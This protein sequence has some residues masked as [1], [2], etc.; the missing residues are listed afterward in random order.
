V[1]LFANDTPWLLVA[2]LVSVAERAAVSYRIRADR[3][4]PDTRPVAVRAP[5][6]QPGGFPP[7]PFAGP[8]RPTSAPMIDPSSPA[9]EAPGVTPSSAPST[10]APAY[11]PGRA[12]VR[13]RMIDGRS[14]QPIAGGMVILGQPGMDLG[15]LIQLYLERRLTDEQFFQGLVGFARTGP[16]GAYELDGIPS[17]QV[18][19]AAGIAQGYR[20]QMLR[21]GIG[22]ESPVLEQNA[23]P[24]LR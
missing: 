13:G 24:M 14:G 22:T 10:Q 23:I 16:D 17:N 8:P 7:N 15:R 20:S 21:I 6:E 1:V 12:T 5:A 2:V 11:G 18:Y 19:P 4:A 3:W 9:P